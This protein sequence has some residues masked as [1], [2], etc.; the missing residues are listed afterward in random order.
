MILLRGHPDA[1]VRGAVAKHDAL[2]G[3]ALAQQTYG[4]T[5]R[6]H[7]IG[8]IQHHDGTSRFCIDQL[9]ELTHVPR[10]ESTADREHYGPVR[11]ALNL[12]QRHY[13]VERNWRSKRNQS[14]LR[15]LSNAGQPRFRQW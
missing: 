9:A 13:R 7:Q 10:V 14:N 2:A 8:Q 6:Q 3:F 4:V 12:E 15:A 1:A 5:I 11:R